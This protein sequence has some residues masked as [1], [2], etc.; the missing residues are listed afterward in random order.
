MSDNIKD[1]MMGRAQQAARQGDLRRTRQRAAEQQSA[2]Y[3]GRRWVDL[4]DI[5]VDPRIQVRAG[6]L[7]EDTV[8]RYATIMFENQSYVPFP[9]VELYRAEGEEDLWLSAGFH[10]AA[11]VEL[12]DQ[13]LVEAG[14]QPIGGVDAFVRPGGWQAAY[15]NAITDNLKHGK[16]MTNADLKNALYRLMGYDEPLPEDGEVAEIARLSNR[17]LAS[18]LGVSHTTIRKWLEEF[19]RQ[20]ESGGN[21]FPPDDR[22]RIGKDG[23]TYNTAAT[24]EANQLRA[25]REALAKLGLPEI[26]PG[27]ETEMA[28]DEVQSWLLTSIRDVKLL[29]GSSGRL[30]PYLPYALQMELEADEPR[31]TLINWLRG[32]L[33]DWKVEQAGISLEAQIAALRAAIL[34]NLEAG[35]MHSIELMAALEEPPPAAYR[36]AREQLKAEGLIIEESG[37]GGRVSFRLAPQAA[38]AA[39]PAPSDNR[40]Q[41]DEPEPEPKPMGNWLDT[42]VGKG[43][44]ASDDGFHKALDEFLGLGETVATHMELMLDSGEPLPGWL[45]EDLDVLARLLHG[46]APEDDIWN[47]GLVELLG[48]CAGRLK[49]QG[50]A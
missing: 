30:R 34:E 7:D 20:A 6:G 41:M 29:L 35:S 11:A 9:P 5:A 26:Q 4:S 50:E 13:W 12:A 48:E 18:V 17:Q 16:Q 21:Q 3:D 39:Q 38:K 15:W 42:P 23:K 24:A 33:P 43:K 44:A 49:G 28:L 10:R 36:A 22:Q 8:H 14:L 40:Y 27:S 37:P 2:E 32:E 19:Q 25:A 1:R 31:M 47:P 45:R 46:Y